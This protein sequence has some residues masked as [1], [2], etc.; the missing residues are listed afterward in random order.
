M[1]RPLRFVTYAFFL[2]ALGATVAEAQYGSRQRTRF[3]GMDRNGDGVITR[4]EWRGSER[5]FEIHDINKDGVLS[6]TEVRTSETDWQ[7]R[8]GWDDLV[9]QFDRTDRDNNG[10]ISRDEWYSDPSTFDRLDRDRNGAIRLSEFLGEARDT[11]SSRA[12]GTSG[13]NAIPTEAYRA[14]F[15]RGLLDG[16]NAGREDKQLRNAWDLEGQRELE[17][18]DAGYDPSMGR[19]DHYQAGYRVGFRQGYPQGFGPR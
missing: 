12:V 4:D 18:A 1:R 17:Q 7:D 8:R 11:D 15:D 13:R 19:L 9:D 2:I 3:R 16:R 5:S 10:V 14:G 6:G